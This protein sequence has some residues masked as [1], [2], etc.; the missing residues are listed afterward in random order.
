MPAMGFQCFLATTR[1]RRVTLAHTRITTAAMAKRNGRRG[2]GAQSRQTD[3]D[4][5]RVGTKHG[6]QQDYVKNGNRREFFF[7][8]C[9]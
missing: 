2:Q 8:I 6:T 5:H 3:F 9:C 4:G 1:G 7:W